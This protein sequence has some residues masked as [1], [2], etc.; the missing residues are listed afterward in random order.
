MMLSDILKQNNF[1]AILVLLI[2]L[3]LIF[4]NIVNIILISLSIIYIFLL[5]TKKIELILNLN[6]YLV[7]LF[8]L[9]IILNSSFKFFNQTIDIENYIKSILYL[10]YFLLYLVIDYLIINNAFF[11][12]NLKYSIILPLSFVSLDTIIQF[13]YGVDLFGIEAS[14]D[15]LTGPFFNEHIPGS[16]MAKFFLILIFFLII[17]NFQSNLQKKI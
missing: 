11:L 15:R 3:S 7:L 8:F 16:Y 13:F 10:R 1:L 9:Y 2:P 17:N 4:G 12:K 6:H 5:I 14:A